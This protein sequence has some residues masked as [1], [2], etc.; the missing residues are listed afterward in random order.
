LIKAK[1][2]DLGVK[3]MCTKK[4]YTQ[5]TG[6]MKA[7]WRETQRIKCSLLCQ[8]NEIKAVSAKRSGLFT[9]YED[10]WGTGGIAPRILK[11]GIL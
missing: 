9:R 10:T 4:L 3:V 2:T 11:L 5:N 7:K 6:R 8:V 1:N